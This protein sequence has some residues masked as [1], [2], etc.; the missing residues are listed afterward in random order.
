MRGGS[1]RRLV[2]LVALLASIGAVMVAAPSAGAYGNTAVYQITFSLNCTS[3]SPGACDQFGG[4][5]GVWGWIEL[6][7]GG[8]GDMTLT[9]CGHTI[10]GGGA[11]AGHENVEITDWSTSG[12]FISLNGTDPGVPPFVSGTNLGIPSAAGHYSEHPFPGL[13]AEITV[14]R[15]PNR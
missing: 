7:A 8:T 2:G 4:P 5:G 14:V 10:G 9:V 6:D 1:M 3:P 11:G 13:A 15:I 12:G